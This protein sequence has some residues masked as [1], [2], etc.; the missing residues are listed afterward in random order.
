VSDIWV[1]PHQ[2]EALSTTPLGDAHVNAN[3][4]RPL[5]ERLSK[6]SV[7]WRLIINSKYDSIGCIC[8]FVSITM[9]PQ[10]WLSISTTTI[11]FFKAR[12]RFALALQSF[13]S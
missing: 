1:L 8:R 9:T 5:S 2:R 12:P 11:N 13:T 3:A 10:A 4:K 7:V 6:Y